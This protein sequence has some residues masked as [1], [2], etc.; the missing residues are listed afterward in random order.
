[1]KKINIAVY[2]W[3]LI[4]ILGIIIIAKQGHTS[5]VALGKVRADSF[6]YVCER[7]KNHFPQYEWMTMKTT[8]SDGFKQITMSPKNNDGGFVIYPAGYGYYE[9]RVVSFGPDSSDANDRVLREVL[10][11]FNESAA[12]YTSQNYHSLNPGMKSCFIAS[13]YQVM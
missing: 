5:R 1:M 7:I 12:D 4:L 2:F 3:I 11:L 13:I 6:D 9:I 8:R 10:T